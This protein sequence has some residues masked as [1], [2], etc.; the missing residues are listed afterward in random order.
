MYDS[1]G[2]VKKNRIYRMILINADFE[3]YY[4]SF[5]NQPV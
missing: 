1:A 3:Y 2:K 5:Y 4:F